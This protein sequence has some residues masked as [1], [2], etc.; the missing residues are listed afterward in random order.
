MILY[1]STQD[2]MQVWIKID[3]IAKSLLINYVFHTAS[4]KR[5]VKLWS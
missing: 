4:N 3:M 5:I 1:R 2:N